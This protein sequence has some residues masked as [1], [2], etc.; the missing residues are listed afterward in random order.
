MWFSLHFVDKFSPDMFH[1]HI[2]NILM[3]TFR[4]SYG[5]TNSEFYIHI[6]LYGKSDSHTEGPKLS[7]T[8]LVASYTYK[9]T[10]KILCNSMTA[11]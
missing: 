9:H 6:M 10:G 2:I 7:T 3:T 5:D 11:G 4:M 8:V 1:D